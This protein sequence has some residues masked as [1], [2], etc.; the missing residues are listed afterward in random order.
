MT[1]ES[2][3]WRDQAEILLHL[4]DQSTADR[5]HS[6]NQFQQLTLSTVLLTLILFGLMILGSRSN[7]LSFLLIVT[8][9]SLG[10]FGKRLAQAHLNQHAMFCH[11][12]R[13][14]I[15]RL[16][17]VLGNA[18]QGELL[19]PFPVDHPLDEDHQGPLN[20]RWLRLYNGLMILA[21]LLCLPLVFG[22]LTAGTFYLTLP[23]MG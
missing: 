21:L 9:F 12:G 13:D 17:T 4:L 16:K 5:R 10:K 15:E 3:P 7:I 20:P 8:L 22:I 18:S 19:P 23:F 1:L 6:E 11:Q 14:Y 2:N